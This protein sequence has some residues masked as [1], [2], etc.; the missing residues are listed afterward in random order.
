MTTATLMKESIQL[1][2]AFMISLVH[3]RHGRKHT[4]GLVHYRHGKKHGSMQADMVLEKEPRALYP[5]RG[6]HGT[7]PSLRI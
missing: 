7:G 3:Y 1:W 5:D 6:Q 2:L 4:R